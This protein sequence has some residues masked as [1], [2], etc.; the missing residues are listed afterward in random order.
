M[1][2]MASQIDE[3]NFQGASSS[4]V[5]KLADNEKERAL[6]KMQQMAANGM[7]SPMMNYAYP[8]VRKSNFS[9]IK[10]ENCNKKYSKLYSN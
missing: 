6:R 1:I 7:V 4:I 2:E 10:K 9:E 3:S 5:V 8:Q